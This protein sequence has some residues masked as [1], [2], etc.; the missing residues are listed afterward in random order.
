MFSNRGKNSKW[1]QAF[2]TGTLPFL[3]LSPSAWGAPSLEFTCWVNCIVTLSVVVGLLHGALIL[4]GKRHCV[5]PAG[6]VVGKKCLAIMKKC[7]CGLCV[8]RVWEVTPLPWIPP[9]PFNTVHIYCRRQYLQQ[10][11]MED[12]LSKYRVGKCCV[13]SRSCEQSKPEAGISLL[14]LPV[15]GLPS[16]HHQL[17]LWKLLFIVHDKYL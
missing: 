13:G 16:L 5:W 7:G 12:L 4:Q 17:E 9:P 3:K 15:W 11:R 1:A 10:L 6:A 8:P 14:C 2:Y